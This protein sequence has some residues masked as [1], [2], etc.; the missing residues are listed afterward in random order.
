[1]APAIRLFVGWVIQWFTS[2]F[3]LGARLC[4]RTIRTGGYDLDVTWFT[5]ER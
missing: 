2:H 5:A 3:L 4:D 1:M